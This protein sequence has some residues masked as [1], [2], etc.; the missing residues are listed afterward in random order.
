MRERYVT[1]GRATSGFRQSCL[2]STGVTADSEN[3][4]PFSGQPMNAADMIRDRRKPEQFVL[5]P[6]RIGPAWCP[7][8][9]RDL[10]ARR[11]S[12]GR[13]PDPSVDLQQ[14]FD[15]FDLHHIAA[16]VRIH[17]LSAISP[18]AAGL[19]RPV[20]APIGFFDQV[21]GLI[22]LETVVDDCRPD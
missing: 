1:G 16:G 2:R 11:G 17:N 13:P 20:E 14:R 19:F 7:H 6:D 15:G 3:G 18:C 8:A 4:C 5:R 10:K 21:H 22:V 9:L 12:S